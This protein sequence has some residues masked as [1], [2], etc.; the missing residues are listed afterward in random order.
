MATPESNSGDLLLR[1]AAGLRALGRVLVL[2]E[3]AAEDVVHDTWLAALEH[4]PARLDRLGGWLREVSRRLASK[5]RRGEARRA[6]RERVASRDEALAAADDVVVER[7]VLREV[8]DAVLGLEEPYQSVVVERYFED[9]P[10]REIASRRG[11]PVAT[12][13]S[14]LSRALVQLRARMDRDAGGRAAWARAL[15]VTTGLDPGAARVAGATGTGAR[16]AASTSR[17]R[18]APSTKGVQMGWKLM[19]GVAVATVVGVATWDGDGLPAPGAG[20]GSQAGAAAGA[21]GAEADAGP[22]EAQLVGGVEREGAD[23][24]GRTEVEPRRAARRLLPGVADPPHAFELAGTVVDSFGHPVSGAHVYLAPPEHPLDDTGETDVDGR[25][26]VTWRAH[27]PTTRLVLCVQ[28]QT[29]YGSGL[30]ELELRAGAP[31]EVR[32]GVLPLQGVARMRKSA[33]AGGNAPF[34]FDPVALKRELELRAAADRRHFATVL[35]GAPPLR[36]VADPLPSFRW[37]EPEL[38]DADLMLTGRPTI[39]G[40]VR[41]SEVK[42]RA[43]VES[44]R[45]ADRPLR[46]GPD[47]PPDRVS[48]VCALRDG[49]GDAVAGVPVAAVVG[50]RRFTGPTGSDG[51]V[52]LDGF[53]AGTPIEL[54]AGG[55]AHGRARTVLRGEAGETLRWE[56]VLDRG[57]EV[58]GRLVGPEGEPLAELRVELES[59]ADGTPVQATARTDAAGRVAF[60]NLPD[61]PLRLLVIPD[62]V[63]GVVPSHRIEGVRPG[64]GEATWIVPAEA[65]RHGGAFTV[66]LQTEDGEPVEDADV[67]LWHPASGRGT[68]L[69]AT[70]E[71][72]RYA[73]GSLPAGSYRITAGLPASGWI[74]L[75]EAWTDGASE[76]D[77]GARVLPRPGRVEVAGD[78]ASGGRDWAL[79]RRGEALDSLVRLGN[80]REPADVEV[81][82]G[83][84]ALWLTGEGGVVPV[85]SFEVED[86]ATTRLA[87]TSAALAELCLAVG[88]G[89]AT[90]PAEF[91]LTAGGELLYRGELEPGERVRLELPAGDYELASTRGGRRSVHALA[92]EAA[93]ELAVDL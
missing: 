58:A 85:A 74:D 4:P 72:G 29:L 48:V 93:G 81:P 90:G 54:T 83:R 87:P 33:P 9:R 55:G 62:E 80:E 24:G 89:D 1:H 36:D 20:L 22:P 43:E 16:R 68:W 32:V 44:G 27:A 75:G 77:L 7:Q 38:P 30:R 40:V 79:V 12:V 46:F 91:R 17:A 3:H 70:G 26:R 47:A 37:L 65:R 31:L 82:A 35:A 6:E 21:Q 56:A 13:R 64:P 69:R 39:G 52:R 45:L 57:N 28:K 15:I 50:E 63:D 25:F 23:A 86:G 2:D 66:A 76:Q 92:V 41:A 84:Y 78:A 49:S 71:P 61:V 8:V 34:P 60:C 59:A 42:L 10:P 19:A 11:V 18:S 5:R 88:A 51:T 14:Q 67:R 53:P 73:A